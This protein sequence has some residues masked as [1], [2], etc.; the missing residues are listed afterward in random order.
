MPDHF[1]F[2]VSLRDVARRIWRRFLIRS[3]AT[4]ADLHAAIQDACGWERCHLFEF[5]KGKIGAVLAGTP[6]ED[7][8]EETGPDAEDVPLASF[9]SPRGPKSCL[10]LYDFGDGWVH[11]VELKGI[12]TSPEAFER[13]LLDGA[14]AFPPE[15]SG[16]VGGYERYVTV[17]TQHQDPWGE[18]I[19]RVLEWLG[20]WQPEEF[21]LA[22][23]RRRF[24]RPRPKKGGVSTE[25]RSASGRRGEDG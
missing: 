6:D 11:D 14:R 12:V 21:D 16:G 7:G 9:F 2:Q 24:D 3:D 19:G 4:F 20:G 10:Y 5:R 18:D 1:D 22:A 17:V 23:V 15:D 8:F 13:R 25:N